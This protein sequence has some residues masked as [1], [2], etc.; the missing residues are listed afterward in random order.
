[1]PLNLEII[2]RTLPPPGAC[3]LALS[4]LHHLIPIAIRTHDKSASALCHVMYLFLE[5]VRGL[6]PNYHSVVSQFP[7]DTDKCF[8]RY[9]KEDIFSKTEWCKAELLNFSNWYSGSDES[10]LQCLG[11][12]KHCRMFISISG[13]H[14]LCVKRTPPTVTSKSVSRHSQI[15][16]WSNISPGWESLAEGLEQGLRKDPGFRMLER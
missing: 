8:S 6:T 3:Q 7:M 2:S 11:C 14:S 1:M 10:I 4:H 12:P 9:T 16:P 15:F 5:R 13:F